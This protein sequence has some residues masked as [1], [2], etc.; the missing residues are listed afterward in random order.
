MRR[1][2]ESFNKTVK[3]DNCII[4]NKA[5]RMFIHYLD[6]RWYQLPLISEKLTLIKYSHINFNHILSES[7]IVKIR[8]TGFIW[9]GAREEL[10]QYIKNCLTCILGKNRGN[11]QKG[12]KNVVKNEPKEMFVADLIE[13]NTVI[14]NYDNNY[15]YMLNIIDHFSKYGFSYLIKDKEHSTIKEKLETV[16]SIFRTIYISYR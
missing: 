3:L 12:I 1:F 9:Y 14:K 7:A 15:T 16:F 13:L 4:C 8:E 5:N 11:V 10:N 6:N 2:R